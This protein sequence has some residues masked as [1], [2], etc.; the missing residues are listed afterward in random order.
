MKRWNEKNKAGCRT[1]S[2]QE[3]QGKIIKAINFFSNLP[4]LN[5]L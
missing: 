4:Q 1:Q 3:L 5:G 2:R